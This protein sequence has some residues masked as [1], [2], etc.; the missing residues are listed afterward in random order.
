M[1]DNQWLKDYGKRIEDLNYNITECV[2]A[3]SADG[4]LD[5]EEVMKLFRGTVVEIKNLQSQVDALKEALILRNKN[6]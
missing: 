6:E 3:G 1:S 4:K 5:L 2:M